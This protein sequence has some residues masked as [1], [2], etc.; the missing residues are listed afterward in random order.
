MAT[1][2]EIPDRSVGTLGAVLAFH[3]ARAPGAPALVFE[4]HTTT[5]A[6]LLARAAALAG[7]LDAQ[8]FRRGDR[9]AYLGKNSDAYFVLLYAA[10]AL[11][12]VLTPLNWR[13][14]E[15]EW[16]FIVEDAGV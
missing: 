6:E 15:S 4:G 1:G 9:L 5:Y 10:A 8:G 14:A 7:E 16:A 2:G 11:G 3:A 12:L 13:L